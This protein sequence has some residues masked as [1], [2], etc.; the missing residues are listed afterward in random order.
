M[1]WLFGKKKTHSKLK[2]RTPLTRKDKLLKLAQSNAYYSVSITRAGCQASSLLINKSFSFQDAPT[3][4]LAN[5]SAEKCTCEYLGLLNRRKY[6]RRIKERRQSLRM[7]GEDRR[8]T[9]RRK[10]EALWNSYSI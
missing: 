8:Q 5:C 3:L 1:N 9:G 10:D 4:P 2:S 7:G 6:Q